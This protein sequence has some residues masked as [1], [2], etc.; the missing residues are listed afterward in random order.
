MPSIHE[1]AARITNEKENARRQAELARSRAEAQEH[2]ATKARNEQ[3]E[4]DPSHQQLLKVARSQKVTDIMYAVWQKWRGT[5]VTTEK[6]GLLR[7]EATVV[8]PMPFIV[9][10][11]S[12]SEYGLNEVY[13]ECDFSPNGWYDNKPFRIYF[14]W[15]DKYEHDTV[16]DSYNIVGKVIVYD[17]EFDRVDGDLYSHSACGWSVTTFES[18]EEIENQI[19]ARIVD[20]NLYG[21]IG[22]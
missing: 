3:I 5:F 10:I 21:Y 4:Q 16:T 12:L 17:I 13:A 2:A 20:G 9:D 18:L 22:R 6:V 14:R 7:R 15:Q 19:V 11:K 1:R 8:K